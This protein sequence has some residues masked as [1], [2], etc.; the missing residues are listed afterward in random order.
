[1]IEVTLDVNERIRIGSNIVLVH[2]PKTHPLSIKAQVAK[3]GIGAP[4]DIKI[5]RS[6]LI[7]N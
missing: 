1:M 5:L 4:L 6:E 7:K 2:L 3:L